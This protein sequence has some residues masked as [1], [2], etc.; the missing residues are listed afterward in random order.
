[1]PT[2]EMVVEIVAS[3]DGTWEKLDFYAAHGVNELLIV[4]PLKHE[5]HWL[6][7]WSDGRYQPTENSALVALGAAALAERIDWL[8]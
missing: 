3:G 6:A 7:L 2:A 4:D 5:V 1:M 8:Q